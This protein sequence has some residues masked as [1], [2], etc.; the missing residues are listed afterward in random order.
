[1]IELWDIVAAFV[2]DRYVS[3]YKSVGFPEKSATVPSSHGGSHWFESSSAHLPQS[4]STTQDKRTCHYPEVRRKSPRNSRKSSAK[5]FQRMSAPSHIPT[6]RYHEQSGQAVV[7]MVDGLGNRRDVL[8]GEDGTAASRGEYL[9]AIAEWQTAGRRRPGSADIKPARLALI[10]RNSGAELWLCHP[11]RGLA[12]AKI[13][14][15]TRYRIS[16]TRPR[17]SLRRLRGLQ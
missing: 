4:K 2:A 8:L 15:S 14:T 10:H 9:S 6:Y 13:A 17:K 12:L 11:G 16:P 3:R 7:T 1:M 5:W